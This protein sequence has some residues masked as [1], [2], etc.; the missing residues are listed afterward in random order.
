MDFKVIEMLNGGVTGFL[1]EQHGIMGYGQ[2]DRTRKDFQA[3]EFIDVGFHEFNGLV[4]D[5]NVFI[6]AVTIVELMM[7][8][9][10]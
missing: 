1:P 5:I 6:F 3:E 9:T 10:G 8:E 4:N 7:K 2:M